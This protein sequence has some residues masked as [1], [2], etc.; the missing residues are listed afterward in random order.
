MKGGR[1][2]KYRKVIFIF[3]LLLLI[4]LMC[5][6]VFAQGIGYIQIQ[7]EP[8]AMVFLDNDLVGKTSSE[9]EGLILQDV[10][11]GSYQIKIV[12]EGFEPQ[13][14]KI[15]LKANEI[16]VY[17]VKEFIPQLDVTQEGEADTDTIKQKVGSLLIETI[18]IDCI[19]EIPKLN[20]NRGHYGDK[21][22]KTWEISNIP[23]GSYR[24]NFIALGKKV[25][26]E[27]KIEEGIQKHLLVNIL[28]NEVKEI[29]PEACN[30]LYF[31]AH[32]TV[33]IGGKYYDAWARSITERGTTLKTNFTCGNCCGDIFDSSTDNESR[34]YLAIP[35]TTNSRGLHILGYFD[36][37]FD[38]NILTATYSF[39]QDIDR[40]FYKGRS[41]YMTATHLY[42]GTI[43]SINYDFASF[44]YKH[45]SF[46]GKNG[47][48]EKD[49]YKISIEDLEYIC[50][51]N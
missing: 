1:K 25:E 20:I 32:A 31:A 10:P 44:P 11:A 17:K 5:L 34:I 36:I 35:S 27:L 23:I 7:C 13:S 15:N 46:T 9:L 12:K 49:T 29:L 4:S 42:I 48:V 26:Y 6:F 45:T 39:Y 2:M 33:F 18:P 28:N 47:Y 51:T 24:V 41:P 19:I 22:K 3:L 14:V 16:Y 38:G 50:R 21:T 37:K 8:G 30:D 40:E 43:P